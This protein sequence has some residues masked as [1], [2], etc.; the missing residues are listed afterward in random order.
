MVRRLIV[1]GSSAAGV[2]DQPA[3]PPKVN[4]VLAR[5]VNDDEDFLYLCFPETPEARAAG[6]ASLRRLDRRLDESNATVSSAAYRAQLAAISS[7]A[8]FYNR[9]DE[10]SLPVLVANGAHDVMINSYATY[11]MAQRLSNAKAILYSDAG[12]GF[13][14]R[15]SEDFALEV[16]RFLAAPQPFATLQHDVIVTSWP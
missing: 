8:G 10:L 11:A 14:F 9:L 6:L 12:H 1:A 16:N 13:L 3:P 2:P 7:F 4:E 15:H 5:S